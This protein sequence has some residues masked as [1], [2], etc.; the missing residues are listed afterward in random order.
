MN[1]EVRCPRC[2]VT[3]RTY[4]LSGSDEPNEG[5]C[6]CGARVS[7]PKDPVVYL[8]GPD[9][10]WTGERWEQLTDDQGNPCSLRGPIG[11]PI[12]PTRGEG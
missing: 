10:V 1:W 12:V 4:R 9:V 6:A 7:M 3:I 5:I 8:R 2:G 11:E